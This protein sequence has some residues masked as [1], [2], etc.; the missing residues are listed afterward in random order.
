LPRIESTN[1]DFDE[2]LVFAWRLGTLRRIL[3]AAA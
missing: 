3:V 1:L 2:I